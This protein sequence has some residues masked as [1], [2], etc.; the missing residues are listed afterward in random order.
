MPAS[1]SGPGGGY[2]LS[3]RVGDQPM[4]GIAIDPGFDFL[5]NFQ[6]VGLEPW[7]VDAVIITHSHIDHIRDLESLMTQR[8]ERND[9]IERLNLEDP[10]TPG[11]DLFLSL[12]TFH[13]AGVLIDAQSNK[14]VAKDKIRILTP[15]STLDLRDRGY[16]LTIEVLSADHRSRSDLWLSHAVSLIFHLY[17]GD[18]EVARIGLTSDSRPMEAHRKAFRDCH[19]VVAHLGTIDFHNLLGLSELGMDAQVEASL[20][21]WNDGIYRNDHDRAML[22]LLLGLDDEELKK[23]AQK[24]ATVIPPELR[25]AASG[26]STPPKE[27]EES[28][29]RL[30]FSGDERFAETMHRS[31]HL[32]YRGLHDVFAGAFLEGSRTR[33]GIISEFGLELGALRHKI[34]DSLNFALFGHEDGDDRGRIVTGDIGLQI[35]LSSDPETCPRGQACDSCPGRDDSTLL[36]IQ[37]TNCKRFFPPSCITDICVRSRQQAIRYNCLDCRETEYSPDLPLISYHG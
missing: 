32:Q 24:E 16:G 23:A 19:L 13:K 28:A 6:A 21:E 27:I 35:R 37:C 12:D 3:W 7:A 30:L 9:T 33:L 2:F 1:D 22:R 25:K 36:K 15:D 4:R 31:A 17:E 11:L 5:S 26:G 34:S 20:A 18:E 29:L 10:Q 8:Y 14:T